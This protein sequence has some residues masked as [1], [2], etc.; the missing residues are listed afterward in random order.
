MNGETKRIARD[1]AQ[2]FEALGHDAFVKR[3]RDD[4]TSFSRTVESGSVD[5]IAV[6]WA[7]SAD[8]SISVVVTAEDV[9]ELDAAIVS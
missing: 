9:T 1:A 5:E 6:E 8:G 2:E 7:E 4:R 3:F